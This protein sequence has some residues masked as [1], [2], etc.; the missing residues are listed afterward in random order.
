MSDYV[1]LS[2]GITAGAAGKISLARTG[3]GIIRSTG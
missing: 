3:L 2:A 1:E